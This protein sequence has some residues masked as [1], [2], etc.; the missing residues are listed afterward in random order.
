MDT[1]VRPY[2]SDERKETWRCASVGYGPV[3]K[4]QALVEMQDRLMVFYFVKI[5]DTTA[6]HI[7]SQIS[8]I[9]SPS[10]EDAFFSSG[11]CVLTGLRVA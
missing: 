10:S 2:E 5:E 7:F 3:A 1:D 8:L 4:E 11:S 9:Y 6:R